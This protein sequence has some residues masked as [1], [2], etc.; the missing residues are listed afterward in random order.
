MRHRI[1]LTKEQRKPLGPRAGKLIQGGGQPSSVAVNHKDDKS[2]RDGSNHARGDRAT[3]KSLIRLRVTVHKGLNQLQQLQQKARKSSKDISKLKPEVWFLFSLVF[4]V[5][6]RSTRTVRTR[7]RQSVQP[8]LVS[9]L[10]QAS[11]ERLSTYQW[12][13]TMRRRSTLQPDPV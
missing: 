10:N 11:F 13:T 3:L 12:S 1:P 7:Q 9:F 2:H 6:H 4:A 8:S 5:N